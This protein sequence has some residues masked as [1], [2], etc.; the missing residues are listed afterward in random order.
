MKNTLHII[1]NYGYVIS[2]IKELKTVVFVL[3]EEN[4]LLRECSEMG[5]GSDEHHRIGI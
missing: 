3:N 5:L 2:K 4:E 1:M